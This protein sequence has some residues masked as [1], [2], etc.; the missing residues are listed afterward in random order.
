MIQSPRA[1]SLFLSLNYYFFI[2]LYIYMSHINQYYVPHPLPQLTPYNIT[3]LEPIITSNLTI[4]TH[5]I[6]SQG[7]GMDWC[8]QTQSW[9]FHVDYNGRRINVLRMGRRSTKQWWRHQHISTLHGT[10]ICSRLR[11]E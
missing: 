9:D 3:F 11:H 10:A 7:Q 2:N 6:F 8:L 1:S 4:Y 5:I